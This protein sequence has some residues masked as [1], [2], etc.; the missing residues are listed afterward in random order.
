MKASLIVILF[1]LTVAT[2]ANATLEEMTLIDVHGNPHI[3]TQTH[4]IN[5][6]IIG[7]AAFFSS[8]IMN[9]L[10]YKIHPSDVDFNPKRFRSEIDKLYLHY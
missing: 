1:R 8:W 10:Y 3:M 9:I 7:W 6:I 5:M 4:V 2:L